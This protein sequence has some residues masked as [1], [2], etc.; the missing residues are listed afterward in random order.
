[1]SCPD[2]ARLT[3]KQKSCCRLYAKYSVNWDN[4]I[5]TV[6]IDMYQRF[7]KL[8]CRQVEAGREPKEKHS[9]LSVETAA[10]GSRNRRNPKFTGSGMKLAPRAELGDGKIDVVV[11]R[12]ATRWQMLKLFT[13]VFDGSHLALE[14]VDYHQVRSFA[15]QADRSGPL[16]L[17]GEMKGHAPVSAEMLPAALSIL[18]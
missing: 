15:I 7:H 9:G 18:A 17:D 13:K 10:W 11:V 3:I 4:D 2:R 16:D 14:F 1:M 12:Q 5:R 8:V 6:L